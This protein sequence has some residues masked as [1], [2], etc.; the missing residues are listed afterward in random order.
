MAKQQQGW[1]PGTLGG[2]RP[3]VTQEDIEEQ[4]AILTV[5]G[6]EE[7][8]VDDPDSPT[9][10]RHTAVLTFAETGDKVLYL[11]K[12][13]GEALVERLGAD[14]QGWVGERVVV[15][16]VTTQFR[17]QKY[18]KVVVMAAEEWDGYL[19]PSRVKRGRR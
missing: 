4:V 14:P 18:P 19:K 15:E 3:K 7:F 8:D 16:K 13:Q 9:G 12:T 5:A 17:N 2:A 10:K 11:N 6:F 1:D